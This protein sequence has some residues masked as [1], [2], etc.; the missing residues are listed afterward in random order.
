MKSMEEII[1]ATVFKAVMEANKP[2]RAE[3]AELKKE[4]AKKEKPPEMGGERLITQVEA[5]RRLG[6]NDK[7][8]RELTAAGHVKL[9]AMPNGRAKVVE[10]TLNSYI[11]Q[12]QEA[13]G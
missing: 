2:L 12:L 10:S 13:T 9:A 6:I 5:R 4:L 11:A 7:A 8:F 3:I 1:A